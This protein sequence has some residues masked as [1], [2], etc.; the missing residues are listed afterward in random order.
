MRERQVKEILA[1][2]LQAEGF[3][4]LT[5]RYGNER[6]VD[7]EAQFPDSGRRLYIEVKGERPGAHETA[8]RRVALGEALLQIF[9]VY[10]GSSVCAIALPNTRGF[11][12]LAQRVFTPL[13]RLEL[14]ALFV[15]EDGEIWHLG[16]KTPAGLPR[17]I[18]SLKE[19]LQYGHGHG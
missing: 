14:H 9:A 1:Q 10:D 6:G 8:K 15:G 4:N 13:S 5:V 16:P 3:M 7:I 11:R 18:S 17:R 2:K 12:S 19:V